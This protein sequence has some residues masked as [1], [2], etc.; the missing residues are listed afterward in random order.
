MDTLGTPVV[1]EA[2]SVLADPK[3]YADEVRLH[4]ALTRPGAHAPV[5]DEE[6]FDDPFTFDV[7]P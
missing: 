7:D 5:F 4:A 3:A 6:I 1:D 2:A